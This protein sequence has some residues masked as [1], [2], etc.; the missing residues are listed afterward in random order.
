MKHTAATLY[1]GGTILPLTGR[2]ARAAGLLVEDG[3]IRA[4]GDPGTLAALCPPGP[5]GG[6]ARR[7]GAAGVCGRPQPLLHGPAIGSHGGPGQLRQLRG[8]R[9]RPGRLRPQSGQRR[10]PGLGLRSQLPPR[11]GPSQ[12]RQLLDQV[13]DRLPVLAVHCSGHVGVANSAAL[14]LAGITET[15]P[16]P[17]GRQCGPGPGDRRAD[18]VSGRDRPV[19]M[20]QRPAGPAADR[21]GPGSG[22]GSAALPLPRYHHGPGRLFRPG[23]LGDAAGPQGP[24]AGG[25]GGLPGP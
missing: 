9:G 1:V 10:D 3:K 18:R 12:P 17:P 19:P 23:H 16:V 24:A 2:L 22:G 5:A 7:C 11:R 14:T 4:V 6:A 15:S 8:H 20:P 25:C 21:P 13:S